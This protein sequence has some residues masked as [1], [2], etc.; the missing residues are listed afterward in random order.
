M[1]RQLPK[2]VRLLV[3]TTAP[4]R[5]HDER[6][7]LNARYTKVASR[8]ETREAAGDDRHDLLVE[9]GVSVA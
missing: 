3:G 8:G 6:N 1:I 4:G 5:L 2:L 9:V 7:Y